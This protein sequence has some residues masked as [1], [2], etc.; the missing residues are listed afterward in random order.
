[1]ERILSI[2]NGEDPYPQTIKVCQKCNFFNNTLILLKINKKSYYLNKKKKQ[3]QG[4]G[5]IPKK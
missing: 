2:S 4:G 1:M 5:L 3:N